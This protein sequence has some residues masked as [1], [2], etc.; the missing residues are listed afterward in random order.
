LQY[1]LLVSSDHRRIEYCQR[2]TG[3]VWNTAILDTTEPLKLR[4]NELAADLDFT[5]VYEDVV[6]AQS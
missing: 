4:C 2:V 3:G 6:L 1:Y 5:R